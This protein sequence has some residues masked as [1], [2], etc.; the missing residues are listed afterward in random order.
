VARWT[1]RSSRQIEDL[2][3]RLPLQHQRDVYHCQVHVSL[4]LAEARDRLR[5]LERESS[6]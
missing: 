2:A 1:W 6:R 5:R 4:A 3:R